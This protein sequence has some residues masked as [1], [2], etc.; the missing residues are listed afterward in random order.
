VGVPGP[1]MTAMS[2]RVGIGTSSRVLDAN[3]AAHGRSVHVTWASKSVAH[4]WSAGG[5]KFPSTR[6]AMRYRIHHRGWWHGRAL[7]SRPN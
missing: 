4:R 2:S 3:L 5:R 1:G 6:F 7:D